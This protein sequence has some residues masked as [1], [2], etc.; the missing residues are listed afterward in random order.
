MRLYDL[1]NIPFRY[2]SVESTYLAARPGQGKTAMVVNITQNIA[3]EQKIPVRHVFAGMSRKN[4]ST[5]F[6][7]GK[8]T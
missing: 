6:W 1:D 5:D 2:A 4:W 3:V 8:L 7:S